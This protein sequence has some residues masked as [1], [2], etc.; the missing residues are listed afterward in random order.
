MTPDFQRTLQVGAIAAVVGGVL[1]GELSG[2]VY[3]GAGGIAVATVVLLIEGLVRRA[4]QRSGVRPLPSFG[5]MAWGVLPAFFAAMSLGRGPVRPLE[6]V[7]GAFTLAWWLVG[8]LLVRGTRAAI[9]PAL[10]LVALPWC[11][12]AFQ[13]VRRVVFIIREGD[14]EG[15]DGYGS[16]FLFLFN[17]M[18]ELA[19]LVIPLTIIAVRLGSALRPEWFRRG[20]LTL[21]AP[22]QPSR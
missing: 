2:I 3:T 20:D 6:L 1:T 16:P 22:P 10:V 19:L 13:T 8:I 5:F 21:S 18:T 15:P 11:L 9:I 7:L 14:M 12:G 4:F 17:W